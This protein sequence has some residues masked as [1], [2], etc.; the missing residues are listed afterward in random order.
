MRKVAVSIFKG[1]TGKSTAACT[2]AVGL[3]RSGFRVVLIDLDPQRSAT[4]MMGLGGER[5][6]PNVHQLIVEDLPVSR[7]LTVLESNLAMIA[8]SE[9]MA[10]AETWLASQMAR[11]QI[12]T[13]RLESLRADFVIMDTSPAFSLVNINALVYASEVWVPITTDYLALMGLKHFQETIGQVET[14][15]G[16]P[17]P[18]RYVIPTFYDDRPLNTGA[19]MDALQQKLGPENI[20]T[21]IHSS[22]RVKEAASRKLTILDHDPRNRV[23]HDFQVLIQRIGKDSAS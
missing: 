7:S 20:T 17:L 3:A 22:V 9:L 12:L 23:A 2:I 18:I 21:P 13:K 15:L 5:N 11:E 6:L 8:G 4:L 1:G 10:P 16:H 14:E 19:I